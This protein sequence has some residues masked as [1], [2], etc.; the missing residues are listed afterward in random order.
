[1]SRVRS[2]AIIATYGEP[3]G[4]GTPAYA[5]YLVRTRRKDIPPSTMVLIEREWL[6]LRTRFE[7]RTTVPFLERIEKDGIVVHPG[8]YALAAVFNRNELRP[9]RIEPLYAAYRLCVLG[10][11]AIPITADGFLVLA[12]KTNQHGQ[13]SGFGAA[14][15]LERHHEERIPVLTAVQDSLAQETP[16]LAQVTNV[17]VL[18]VV[19][20]DQGDRRG[21]DIAVVAQSRHAREEWEGRF[22][23]SD[24]FA[25]DLLF[26][27]PDADALIGMLEAHEDGGTRFSPS[28]IATLALYL[29][30]TEGERAFSRFTAVAR[31][32]GYPLTSVDG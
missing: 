14:F 7:D 27:E 17:R 32:R 9:A 13:Y 30:S 28:A 18:G 31:E 24:Q 25:R 2:L 26:V 29:R 22:A 16:D 3:G 5:T 20:F 10:Q 8:R 12:R 1:M 15:D 19:R 11:L 4:H 21:A 23:V 6:R